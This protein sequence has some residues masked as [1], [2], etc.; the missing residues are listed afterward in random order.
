ML[1]NSTTF[2][3]FFTVFLFLY[4]FC[5]NHLK[6]RNILILVGSYVFY[7][8]WDVRFLGLLVATS[9]VDFYV[10]RA[11]HQARRE[12]TRK[13]ILAI[14]IGANLVVLGI[15]KYYDFFALSF[16]EFMENLGLNVRMNT[17]QLILPVGISFYTFQSMSYAIDIYRRHL[18]PSPDVVA[19]LAYVA[20]FPQLVAGPIERATHLLPQFQKTSEITTQDIIQGLWLIVRGFFKKVVIADNLDALV[21]LV[22]NFTSQATGPLALLGAL[23]FGLQVYCDFSGYSDIARGAAKWLGFDLMVNFKLPYF[24][25]SISDFWRRWHISLSTWIRDYLYLPLGGNRCSSTRNAANVLATMLLAG[26][27]HGAHIN[28]ALWGIWHGAALLI[29][30]GIARFGALTERVWM[31]IAVLYGWMLFRARDTSQIYNLNMAFGDW[32]APFWF[33]DAVLYL[34]VFCLPL[35]LLEFLEERGVETI[36][37][38][39][40]ALGPFVLAVFFYWERKTTPFIYF[41]F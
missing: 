10:G 32:T 13:W 41:Q 40:F 23:A 35:I 3:I 14:S 22:F 7:G 11:L 4:Y 30:R 12:K 25:R 8:W 36:W 16:S 1:F 26:L 31:W 9:L 5:R 18:P 29:G 15:F 19:F 38:P 24:S 21:G 28:F 39:R 33:G 34:V 20:F 37:I 2:L 6:A 27:W 17:L